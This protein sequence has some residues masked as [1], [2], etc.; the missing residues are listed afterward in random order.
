L[1]QPR[2]ITAA[3]KK[4]PNPA[5]AQQATPTNRALGAYIQDVWL[6]PPTKIDRFTDLTNTT[7]PKI[8]P[9]VVLYFQNWEQADK[10]YFD[11]TKMDAVVDRGAMPMVTWASRD[12][13]KGANQ[14]KYTDKNI[15]NGQF[16]SYIKQWAQDAANWGESCKARKQLATPCT[17]YLRFDHEMNGTWFPWSPGVNN[18]T[19]ADWINMWKHV[20]D[21]FQQEQATVFKNNNES[22][23]TN[24]RWVWSPHV[25]CGGCSSLASVYPGGSYVDWA[26]LDGYN[27]GSPWYTVAQI[28]ASSYDKITTQIAPSKPFMIAEIASAEDG[29]D[30][31]RKAKW[32]EDAYSTD[33]VAHPGSIPNRMPLTQAVVWFSADKTAQGERDW[34]VNSSANSLQAYQAVVGNQI[35]QGSLPSQ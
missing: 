26:A 17:M 6:D 11:A 29:Q 18:N 23:T 3:R 15:I 34:R 27:W 5:L 7:Q 25:N 30:P 28:F 21:V 14:K 19:T 24:V 33:N 35:W 31:L 10:K 32:I 1:K 4:A 20:H 2:D 9:H 22:V 13:T 12:P 8:P 16:D